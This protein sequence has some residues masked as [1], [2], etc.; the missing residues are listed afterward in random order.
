VKK[1]TSP[2]GLEK[3]RFAVADKTVSEI[4]GFPNS[5]PYYEAFHGIP[6]ALRTDHSAQIS[7]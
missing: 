7:I 2:Q 3:F 4:S 5:V 1:Y 6:S